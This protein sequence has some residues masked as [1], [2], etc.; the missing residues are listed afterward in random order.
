M[1]EDYLLS[2]VRY[3]ET[4]PVRAGLCNN[5]Q[6]WR[7][8]SANAHLRGQ[9]DEL[10]TVNPMLERV[11]CWP[12]FLSDDQ[13]EYKLDAIRMHSRTGRPIGSELFLDKLQSV[14]NRS[15]RVQKPGP[16]VKSISRNSL[17]LL[18]ARAL[19]AMV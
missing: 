11:G 6:D 10:V 2:T 14:V 13:P 8:S 16:K 1:D 12:G 15:I 9:D 19:D 7:W 18:P 3:A 4:N 17:S 5:P